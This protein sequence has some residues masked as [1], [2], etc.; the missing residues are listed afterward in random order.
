LDVLTVKLKAGN[1][2]QVRLRITDLLGKEI[3]K[4]NTVGFAGNEI[5]VDVRSW[6]PQF[7]I[8]TLYNSKEEIVG[9]QKFV[10]Q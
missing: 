9:T 5:K 2:E 10:K 6:K 4:T 1:T 7:Y 3:F 8:L